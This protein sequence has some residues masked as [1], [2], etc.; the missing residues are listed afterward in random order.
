MAEVHRETRRTRV[1]HRCLLNPAD[2][3]FHD[4]S[5]FIVTDVLKLP[6]SRLLARAAGEN[7]DAHPLRLGMRLGGLGNVH[8]A[9]FHRYTARGVIVEAIGRI[10]LAGR[11][12]GHFSVGLNCNHL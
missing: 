11:G 5:A 2:V 4:T 3:T 6:T 10:K 9:D 12:P 7:V 1:L 8:R